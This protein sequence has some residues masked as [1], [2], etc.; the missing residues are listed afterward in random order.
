MNK[1]LSLLAVVALFVG[2]STTQPGSGSQTERIG[3]L[4]ELAAYTGTAVWLVDHPGD[5]PKFRAA[6]IALGALTTGD[7]IALH[8]ILSTLPIKELKSEKGAIIIGVAILLYEAELPHLTPINQAS[9]AALVAKRIQSG[10][11]LAL[12]PSQ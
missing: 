8:Q 7:P 5:A 1:L 9:L 12:Q 2:C 3:N 6:A 10:I 4:V 11:N